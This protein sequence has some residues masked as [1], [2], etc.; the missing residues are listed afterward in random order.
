MY[1][2]SGHQMT[3]CRWHRLATA[4]SR[5][6]NVYQA[7]VAA[8][9]LAADDRVPRVDTAPTRN[10]PPVG[11]TTTSRLAVAHTAPPPPLAQ[12]QHTTTRTPRQ[13]PPLHRTLAAVSSC[14]R[15]ARLPVETRI[16]RDSRGGGGVPATPLK[17]SPPAIQ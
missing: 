15:S 14:P 5:T 16:L 1:L 2:L 10:V 13:N 11:V 12:R 7:A 3:S 6:R 8:R 17:Y 4:A 9:E